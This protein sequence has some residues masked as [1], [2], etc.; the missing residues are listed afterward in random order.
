MNKMLIGVV[1][2]VMVVGVVG[3]QAKDIRQLLT[4]EK[5]AQ[6]ATHVITLDYSDVTSVTTSN[7]AATVVFTNAIAQYSV[8]QGIRYEL[9]AAWKATTNS[10]N[11]AALIVGVAS[12]TS[13][14]LRSTEMCVDGTEIY[15]AWGTPGDAAYYS[16]SATNIVCTVTPANVL[17]VA[18]SAFTNGQ[19]R[20]YLKI[21]KLDTTLR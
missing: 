20:V 7:T 3:V 4:E 11:S 14:I 12:A 13:N 6:F 15:N 5:A 8:V 16:A 10:M 18:L 17:G 19:T 9:P 1:L 21:H 2:A